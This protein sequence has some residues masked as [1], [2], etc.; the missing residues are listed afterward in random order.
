MKVPIMIKTSYKKAEVPSLVDGGATDNF[1]N[2]QTV[3]RLRLGITKLDQAK[4]L[5]NIDNT[6]NKAGKVTHFVNLDIT[7]HQQ[8]QKMH[9]LILDIGKESIILGYPW[10]A[11]FKPQ[12]N[13]KEGTLDDTYLPIVCQSLKPQVANTPSQE[14]W[15]N[16][17]SELEVEC[18]NWT[19]SMDLAINTKPKEEV[20]LPKEYQAFA[21]VFSKEEVQWFPPSWPWDHTIDFKPGVP[22]AI[23]CSVYPMMCAKDNAL[24]DFLDEQLAKGYIH[25]SISPYASSFFIKKKDNKLQLV[26]DY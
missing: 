13:W 25:P 8:S 15:V 6:Q 21:L 9:F 1:I 20:Y 19:I 10:L 24:D 3:R 18:T 4:R 26:Q 2:P 14:E 23:N 7:T 5:F 22:N 11:A 12:F 17:L 16:A